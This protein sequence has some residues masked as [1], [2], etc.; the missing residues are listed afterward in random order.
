MLWYEPELSHQKTPLCSADNSKHNWTELLSPFVDYLGG[1]CT[2]PAGNLFVC[3]TANNKLAYITKEGAM[4]YYDNLDLQSPAHV[5][6]NGKSLVVVDNLTL[7]D[8]VVK[9]YQHNQT[10]SL[11]FEVFKLLLWNEKHNGT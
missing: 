5:A 1:L 8:C 7:L 3:D 6:T 10:T 11:W 2:E 4:S 9:V